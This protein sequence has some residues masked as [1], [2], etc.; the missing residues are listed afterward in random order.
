MVFETKEFA[1]RI[2]RRFADPVIG[3]AE[4]HIFLVPVHA[5]PAGISL[6][7]NARRPK[8]N[9]QIYRRVRESLFNEGVV[10]DGTFHLK[11]K[12]ITI[13]AESVK[14]LANDRY[15]V[16]MD[17]SVHGILDGG[18]TYTLIT[19]AQDEEGLP[20][21]QF[22]TVEVR[23]G[24]PDFLIPDIA[25]GLNTA[26][27]VQAMSLDHLAGLFEWLKDELRGEPYFDKIAWSENDPG[28]F[29]ARDLISI[30]AC[31]NVS[32][33]PNDSDS[34]PVAAFEKKS[35]MLDLFEKDPASFKALRPIMKDILVLHDTI[36]L[37]FRQI[38]NA[39]GGGKAGSGA[40][41]EGGGKAARLSFAE[42]RAKKPFEFIFIG[43]SSGVRMAGGP[44]MAIL[45]AFRWYVQP[46]QMTGQCH[47]RGGFEN[48]LS[49]WHE[50]G[51]SLLRATFDMSQ[52]MSRNPALV[53]KSRPHWANLHNILA[54][55]DLVRRAS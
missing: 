7:P 18:H 23:T 32:H 44:L 39:S 5:L 17:P 27:Q 3:G 55:N 13:V 16:K 11:N 6:E 10:M 21:N 28:A 1:V 43:Q 34:H 20:E 22:V 51:L 37:E 50:D 24:L 12:G 38:W 30:L 47:W 25:G 29:D 4:R 54:K 15:S 42:S 8:T 36:S 52:Q 40:E 41:P 45:A 31:F 14:Q 35:A 48:V 19:E 49:A 46:D 26:V 33:F 2:A 53:G 9:K